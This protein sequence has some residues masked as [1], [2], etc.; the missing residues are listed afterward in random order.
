ML[1]KEPQLRSDQELAIVKQQL[2]LQSDL[3]CGLGEIKLK[4]YDGDVSEKLPVLYHSRS[5]P[6]AR[7]QSTSPEHF[8]MFV[9]PNTL[10]PQ[11][12]DPISPSTHDF[13]QASTCFNSSVVVSVG[14]L[15]TWT[16]LSHGPG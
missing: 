13:Y 5:R 16:T 3:T 8:H 2:R 11:H 10:P 6:S 15:R 7:P 9:L 4:Y 1:S 12:M 14:V